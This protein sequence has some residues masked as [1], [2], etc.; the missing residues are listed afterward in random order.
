MRIAI[1]SNVD[2]PREGI[3]VWVAAGGHDVVYSGPLTPFDLDV[4]RAGA[5]VAIMGSWTPRRMRRWTLVGRWWA[6]ERWS[7]EL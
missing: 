1:L 5:D 4:C 3:R 7:R 2:V 6:P